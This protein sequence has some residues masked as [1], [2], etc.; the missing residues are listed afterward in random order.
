MSST[1]CNQIQEGRDAF[2]I[3][4]HSLVNTILK[5]RDMVL[6]KIP[7]DIMH[8]HKMERK[9]S[10]IFHSSKLLPSDDFFHAAEKSSRILR[11]KAVKTA[12]SHNSKPQAPKHVDSHGAPTVLVEESLLLSGD[13]HLHLHGSSS[14]EGSFR[15][16]VFSSVLPRGGRRRNIE[17]FSPPSQPQ[18]GAY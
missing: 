7:I 14:K 16:K 4:G 18:V 5:R 17:R 11:N 9:I 8:K 3:C 12:V 15:L 2:Q 1:V 10:P 6:N 13:Q